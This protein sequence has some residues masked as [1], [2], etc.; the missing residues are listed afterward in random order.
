MVM[1]STEVWKFTREFWE[2]EDK[3]EWYHWGPGLAEEAQC[4]WKSPLAPAL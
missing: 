1:A 2:P 3:G 4:L